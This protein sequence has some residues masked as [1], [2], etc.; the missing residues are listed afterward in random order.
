[1]GHSHRVLNN[2]APEDLGRDPLFLGK[3][4]VKTVNQDVGINES[5]HDGRDP[6]GSN[7]CL[8]IPASGDGTVRGAVQRPDRTVSGELWDLRTASAFRLGSPESHHRPES[9]RCHHTA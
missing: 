6:L 2:P 4:V 3:P 9:T 1:M 8:P 7:L 5:G